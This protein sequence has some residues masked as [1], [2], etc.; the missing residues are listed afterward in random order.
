MYATKKSCNKTLLV[1][2][3]ATFDLTKN[4]SYFPDDLP[5]LMLNSVKDE[6]VNIAVRP[7]RY[8]LTL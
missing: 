6:L 1:I 8:L 4:L 5:T 7:V 2:A 3:K